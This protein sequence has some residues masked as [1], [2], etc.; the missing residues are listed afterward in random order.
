MYFREELSTGR[1]YLQIAESR[2][3]GAAGTSR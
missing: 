3:E 2:F 1:A